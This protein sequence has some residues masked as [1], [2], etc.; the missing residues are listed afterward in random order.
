MWVGWPTVKAILFGAKLAPAVGDWYL[1][2]NG[3]GA[4]QTG[5]PRD[6]EKPND[7]WR[8]VDDAQGTD[9][10][11]RG[12]FGARSREW[13]LMLW[14]SMHRKAVGTALVVALAAAGAGVKRLMT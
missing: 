1:A 3:Y 4:Q 8:P 13:S 14:M 7:L 5:E 12:T 11:A 9:H 6:S 2:K 10:G